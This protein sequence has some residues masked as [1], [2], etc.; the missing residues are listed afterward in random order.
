MSA[1]K[2]LISA[3]SGIVAGVAI[4]LLVAPAKGSETR[5][6]ISDS[7]SNLKDKLGRLRGA[8]SEEL[9]ELTDIFEH[10]V[11]GLKDDVRQRVLQLIRSS[12]AAGNHLKEQV[13]S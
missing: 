8:T 9:K 10:E 6:K 12:K 3:L 5:Q 2:I 4:G 13:L 11:E 1:Q 7:A